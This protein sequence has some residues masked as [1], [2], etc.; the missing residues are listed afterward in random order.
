MGGGP[1]PTVG[2]TS[3]ERK[4][5]RDTLR[6][7]TAQGAATDGA[8]GFT[9]IRQDVPLD[10]CT[11]MKIIFFCDEYPPAPHGGIG[12]FTHTIAHGLVDGGH[13]VTVV[14]FG[15]RAQH[16]H[17]GE[18]R[19]VMLKTARIPKLTWLLNRLRLHRWLAKE[20]A[21]GR[22]DVIEVPEYSGFLPFPFRRC[23]VV[24]R[25]HLSHTTIAMSAQHRP[26]WVIRICE[27][28]TLRAHRNWIAVSEH[29]QRLTE[30]TFRVVPSTSRVIYSPVILPSEPDSSALPPLPERFVLYAGT[31]STRKG[32][33]LVA[34]AAKRFLREDRSTD[35][36][37]AGTLCTEDDVQ[38][39]ERIDGIVGPELAHRVHVLGFLDR[40]ALAACMRRAC[41]FVFPSTLETFG[42]VVG[43]AMLA[44]V[45]VVV[46]RGAP[47]DE[48]VVA[49]ESGLVVQPNNPEALS[50]AVLRLLRSPELCEQLGT[51]GRHQIE[52]RFSLQR[53]VSA[54]EVFYQELRTGGS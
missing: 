47:F 52:G 26:N 5:F 36:V 28:L 32:A 39:D 37:Y 22:V 4:P 35:L 53:A 51:A 9:P 41:V 18:V 42:L 31:L 7:R 23:P 8:A 11:L 16:W 15:E 6:S 50:Q 14:G 17:D 44:G 12:T 24:V 33:Y 25:I 46:P 19:M 1:R 2:P 38:S 49:E 48:F 27:R 3:L 54:T 20:A 34:E 13:E 43:E 10:G 21:G 29:A 45:P 40:A 30:A